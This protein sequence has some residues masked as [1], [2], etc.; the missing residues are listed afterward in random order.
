LK[1]RLACNK[2]TVQNIKGNEIKGGIKSITKERGKGQ[3]SKNRQKRKNR[4]SGKNKK[5]KPSTI[6]LC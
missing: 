6:K 1:A 3:G 5:K 2:K 4:D